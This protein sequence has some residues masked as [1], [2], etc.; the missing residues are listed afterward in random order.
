MWHEWIA[1]RGL[2]E[3]ASCILAHLNEMNTNATLVAVRTATFFL[4]V[5]GYMLYPIQ[6]SL[7]QVLITSLWHSYLPND[8]DFDHIEISR[9]TSHTYVPEDWEKVVKDA[10]HENPFHVQKMKREDFVTLK[11][12]KEAIVNRKVNTHSEKV[13]WLDF[14]PKINPFN[15]STGIPTTP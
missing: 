8:Q 1:L 5:C 11:P 7:L 3:V 9:K 14:S 4:S 2:H 13:E 12:L 10:R 15:T 6:I